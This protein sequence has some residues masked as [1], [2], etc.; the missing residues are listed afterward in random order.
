M[1]QIGL[2]FFQTLE[3]L[4]LQRCLLCVSHARLHFAFAIGVAHPAGQGHST[5]VGQH[6]TVEGI[7]RGFVEIGSQYAFAQ[8]VQHHHPCGSAQT[9]EGA[10][11]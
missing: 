3:A 9:A 10:F 11:M 8:I 1:I 5:V 2:S 4:T 6:I 7:E